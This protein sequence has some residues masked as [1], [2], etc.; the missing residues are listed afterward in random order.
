L[1]QQNASILTEGLGILEMHY[2]LSSDRDKAK[3]YLAILK[4]IQAKSKETAVLEGEI[5]TKFQKR[6]TIDLGEN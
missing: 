4:N 1:R 3:N 5:F 2:N 6:L